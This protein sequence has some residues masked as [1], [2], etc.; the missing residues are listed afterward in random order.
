MPATTLRPPWLRKK[1]P[2]FGHSAKVLATIREGSL[3][4]VCA[5]ACCPNQME[6]FSRGTATFLLLGPNCT[7]ACRFCAVAKRPVHAPDPDEPA[8]I[9]R[10]VSRMGV[11]FCVL[12][13]VT[14]DD[15][16]DG[17]AGHVAQTVHTVRR[18][19]PGIDVEVLISDLAGNRG[20]LETI[21]DGAPEVLNHNIETVPRLYPAVRPQ[22]DYRRSVALLNH[23]REKAPDIIT[24]SGLMLGLGE[25]TREVLAV[26][27]D[28]VAAGCRLLTLG[29]YL[30]P[31]KNH[32]PVD[33]YVTPEA[34]DAYRLE[35]ERRGFLGVAS[36][37]FVRSSYQAGEL[38]R[39]ARD[40]L[41]KDPRVK[42]GDCAK[43]VN[44]ADL[45]PDGGGV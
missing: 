4:T 17:G 43:K 33:S 45:P 19:C 22:A 20:A 18:R 12:T 7:R 42:P 16:P 40:K 41:K 31:S 29:Q 2:A 44:T 34:F 10:S 35:A 38:Y 25:T 1:I 24:K 39:S 30:T 5:E 21:L 32:Y 9:A 3:H 15:L 26:M 28:L 6:C 37:P 8:R 11:N 14:R 36:A 27:D 13:M 23:C